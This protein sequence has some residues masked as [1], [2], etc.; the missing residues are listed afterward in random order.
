VREVELTTVTLVAPVRPKFTV[1]PARKFVPVIVTI[2][3][4]AVEPLLGATSATVGGGPR[5]TLLNATACMTQGPAAVRTAD[6]L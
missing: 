1:A 3:P 4:P 2:V 5:T 6:A